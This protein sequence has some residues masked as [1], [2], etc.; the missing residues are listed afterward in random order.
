MTKQIIKILKE[1]V[2]SFKDHDV[3]F[4]GDGDL[5]DL[6]N[7]LKEAINFIPCCTELCECEEPFVEVTAEECGG[8]GMLIK[9]E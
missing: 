6:A 8:C 1:H 3:I 9:G 5:T 4:G 2:V 7:K